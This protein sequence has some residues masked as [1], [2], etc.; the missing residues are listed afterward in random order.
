MLRGSILVLNLTHRILRQRSDGQR[1]VDAGVGG[2][3]GAVHNVQSG[4]VE[5]LEIEVDHAVGFVG[6]ERDAAHEV[7]GCGKVEERIREGRG[8]NAVDLFGKGA[9]DFVGKGEAVGAVFF[10]VLDDQSL[11][12]EG[13]ETASQPHARQVFLGLHDKQDGCVARPA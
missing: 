10:F 1:R 3:D 13:E 8:G 7:S 11:A 6:A 5:D 9:G 12:P 4:I 2:H